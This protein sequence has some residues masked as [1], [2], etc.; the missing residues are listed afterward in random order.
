SS[1]VSSCVRDSGAFS[2]LCLRRRPRGHIHRG[3][4]V[5]D[6]SLFEEFHDA[7][8][9]LAPDALHPA[10]AKERAVGVLART[11]V[12]RDRSLDGLD[13]LPE[14]HAL[15][16]PRQD[17]SPVRTASGAN[18][19][20]VDQLLNDLLEELAWDALAFRDLGDG[21]RAITPGLP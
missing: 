4:Y 2:Q 8:L 15:R 18:E 5:G 17:V 14:S 20:R 10:G 1:I 11:H 6:R 9:T 13:H 21:A 3:A 7:P 16:R 19:S 12:Q